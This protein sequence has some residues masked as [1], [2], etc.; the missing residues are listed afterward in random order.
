MFQFS[1]QLLK[2]WQHALAEIAW[3]AGKA[4]LDIYRNKAVINVSEKED[5]SPVTEADIAAH[6][7]IVSALAQLDPALPILSEESPAHDIE[8]RRQWQQFW[9]VDPLDGT[10]DFLRRNDEFTV[11]IALIE[12]GKVVLSVVLAP[13]L[14]EGY[15]ARR[16]EQAWRFEP[17]RYRDSRLA[18]AARPWRSEHTLRIAESRSHG[19]GL[20]EAW[21]QR[22]PAHQ[23]VAMGS[24]LK[25][26][27][28][29]RG[30]ADLYVR[31]G[32]TSEWDTAA[33]QFVLE[34]AG[35]AVNALEGTRLGAALDYNQRDTLINPSFVALAPGVRALFETC[36]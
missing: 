7:I 24:S 34:Q 5:H 17:G 6:R 22:L 32:P 31:C 8:K 20:P 28:I 3:Q 12:R 25:F 15:T 11:N 33:A 23:C 27:A 2:Q 14:E 30:D 18:I 13:A 35:G 29:A 9:L 4:I 1:D 26:C 19:R 16:G 36:H 21:L 10:R